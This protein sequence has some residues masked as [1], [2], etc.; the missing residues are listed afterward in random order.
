MNIFGK[1]LRK[2]KIYT[3]EEALQILS[4]EKYKDCTALEKAPGEWN[5]I[6]MKESRKLETG[7]RKQATFHD[8]ISD[9]KNYGHTAMPA[10]QYH[11]QNQVQ[12]YQ[13]TGFEK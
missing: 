7:L 9:M 2:G 10:Y 6:T 13:T 8:R 12:K 4:Q 1:K 11:T 3:T 5:I